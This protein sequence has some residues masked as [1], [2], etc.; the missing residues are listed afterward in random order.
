LRYF[1]VMA[2]SAAHPIFDGDDE[3]TVRALRGLRDGEL[4]ASLS[5]CLP[6]A[7]QG[8]A[9]ACRVYVAQYRRLTSALLEEGR[10]VRPDLIVST[11]SGLSFCDPA[12]R[13]ASALIG[14]LENTSAEG[15]FTAWA[16]QMPVS[17]AAAL[18]L[19]NRL[20]GLLGCA[21][22]AEPSDSPEVADDV[23]AQRF[24]RRVRFH[25]N[26]PDTMSPLQRI[27][28]AFDL[29][30]TDTARLFGVSRQAI[31]QWLS[32]GVPTERQEK[33]TALLALLDILQRK[34]KAD[35][36]PGIAR[37]PAPAYGGPTMLELIAQDRHDE[38]LATTRESF[39]WHQAA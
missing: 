13:P 4:L 18:H 37:R 30:K 25:L 34:L 19:V 12:G 5:M 23:A 10:S 27:M 31:S 26:H 16:L 3:Q 24:L 35:R 9:D 15:P 32:D 17:E 8:S 20:R 11:P 1:D 38:L 22:L 6:D 21:V 36:L 33:V 39:A 28:E 2:S 14:V 7:L 29:S